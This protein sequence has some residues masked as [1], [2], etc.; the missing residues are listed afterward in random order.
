MRY[1]FRK[2]FN[3]FILLLVFYGIIS[4]E[5]D[6]TDIGS[7]IIDNTKFTTSQEELGIDIKQVNVDE[8]I[9]DNLGIGRTDY[10]LGVFAD[11]S[12]NYRKIKA[13]IVSQLTIIPNLEIFSGADTLEVTTVID[14][15]FLKIQYPVLSNVNTDSEISYYDLD[16]TAIVGD[17]EKPF[18]LNV[19]Q[20]GTYLNTLNPS[21]PAKRNSYSSNYEFSKIGS[22]LNIENFEFRPK[23]S[24]TVIKIE[25]YETKLD[26]IKPDTIIRYKNSSNNI[27]LPFAVIPLKKDF[28]KENFLDKYGTTE[29]SSQDEFNNYFNGIILEATGDEGTI[30]NLNF[31]NSE[32]N[33]IPSIEIYYTST[34]IKDNE[35]KVKR[36]NHSFLL[37]GTKVNTYKVEGNTAS[38][39]DKIRLQGTVGSEAVID[40]FVNDE[41]ENGIP[42]K[43]EELREKNILL[44]EASLTFYV[45]PGIREDIIPE[46]LYLYKSNEDASNPI[47]SKVIDSYIRLTNSNENANVF[48][49]I[50]EKA[51][52]GKA[53]KY[54]IV[55]TDYILSILSGGTNYFPKLRLKVANSTEIQEVKNPPAQ[56]DID[57]LYSNYNWNPRAVTLYN[58]K[59]ENKDKKA[60]FKIFYS[61]NKN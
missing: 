26:T 10:L 1:N 40:I 46:R 27:S 34:Y 8:V 55:I 60:V 61:E 59:D 35:D 5:K 58:N 25:R 49:G 38:S 42:D 7:N 12:N 50:L 9:S 44:N 22:I 48:G 16:S 56:E 31:N 24:D 45:D 3:L 13:S 19:Y 54:T 17:V 52:D 37:S 11:A 2:G 57:T 18:N 6:F 30:I 47:R 51:D 39:N 14:T 32:T 21:N 41:N 43:I 15:V 4:C 36:S 20:L 33:A 53:E 29:F 28:F 23:I